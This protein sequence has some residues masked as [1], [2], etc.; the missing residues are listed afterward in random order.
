MQKNKKNKQKQDE[1]CKKVE[2]GGIPPSSVFRVKKKIAEFEKRKNK[3]LFN[4]WAIIQ[5]LTEIQQKIN[6][7]R[8]SKKQ[9][10][11]KV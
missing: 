4:F 11:N 5:K 10:K 1:K 3:Y 6:T 7:L 2:V 9:K 8:N